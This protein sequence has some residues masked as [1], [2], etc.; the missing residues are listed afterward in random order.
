MEMNKTKT[1]WTILVVEDD[2]GLNKLIQKKLERSGFQTESV[3]RGA[4]AVRRI[5]ENSETLLLL[6]DY[7]L[8]DMTGDEVINTLA[9]QKVVVPFLV[10]TGQGD[11]RIAVKMMKLGA[12]NYLIKEKDFLELLPR[13]VGRLIKELAT[14][15][16]LKASEEKLRASEEKYRLLFETMTQGVVFY[17]K[18]GR[19]TSANPAAERIF[20]MSQDQIVGRTYKDPGYK[21]IHEDRSDFPTETHP[22]IISLRT[23]KTLTNVIMGINHPGEKDYRWV[24][25]NSI[26]KYK[27]GQDYPYEA[28]AIFTDITELKKIENEILKARNFESLR[29]L[30][31]GIAHDFNNLLTAIF[32]Y[33]QLAKHDSGSGDKNKVYN[34]LSEAEKASELARGLTS[35]LLTFSKG[36]M[37]IKE[38]GSIIDLVKASA[39]FV[40]SGTKIKCNTVLPDDLWPIEM[41]KGQINQVIHNL[42]INAK[43][44]MPEGGNIVIQGENIFLYADN[45]YSLRKGKYVRISITDNGIGIDQKILPR[46]FEPYFSQKD[47]FAHKG[48]GLGLAICHSVIAKHSGCLDVESEKGKGTTFRIYLP[49]SDQKIT[50]KQFESEIEKPNVTVKAKI[51]IMEDEEVVIHVAGSMMKYLGYEPVFAREGRKALTLYKEAM[52]SGE[53]FNTVILDLTVRGGMGGEETIKELRKIDPG[54]RA[55]VTSGYVDNVVMKNYEEYGFKAALTKPFILK[56]LKDVLQKV[57][58]VSG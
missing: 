55:I 53:P 15:E 40:L 41:D 8:P 21:S 24:V 51:L 27:E 12:R 54:V 7:Q 19:I 57:C 38:T 1:S 30:A 56:A 18:N 43:E 36:G 35:Q 13:V 2:E 42:L 32:G 31:G 17:D 44:A 11:E 5:R 28:Y 9:K 20:G 39:N 26:P 33:I 6:L 47:K 16:L 58:S 50:Q 34:Y 46:I 48:M 14:D 4:D 29:V 3:M 25:V 23:G 45:P 49:S 10:M 37:P 22:S 52:D